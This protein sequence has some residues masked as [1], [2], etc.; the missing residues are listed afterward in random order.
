MSKF[1]KNNK[2]ILVRRRC[3]RMSADQIYQ[4]KL[5]LETLLKLHALPSQERD[6][7]D[8]R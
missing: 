2:Y 5:C 4:L 6:Q 7:I 3:M 1:L 8:A